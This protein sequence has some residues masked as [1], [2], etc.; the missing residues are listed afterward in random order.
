MVV[1]YSDGVVTE[2]ASQQGREVGGMSPRVAAVLA[3]S[4]WTLCVALA[5]L[6]VLLALYALPFLGGNGGGW[7]H[8]ASFGVLL[9]VSLL[10][11][12]TVGA[13]VASRRPKNPVGWLL[14]GVGLLFGTQGFAMTY[15]G[16][17]L[18]SRPGLLSGEKIALW[19]SNGWFTFPL[20][21]LAAMLIVLLFPDGR[22]PAR[23]LWALIWVAVG[24]ATLWTLWWATKVG[25][26]I[27]LLRFYSP[28]HNPFLVRGPLGE[29]VEVLGRL[30]TAVFLVSC[31]AS[32]ISV[33]VR[34]GDSRGDERQQIKWFAYAAAALLGAFFFSP[35]I[36]SAIAAMGGPWGL[37]L[38]ICIWAGLQGIPVAVGIA[39]LKYRLY[40]IDRLINRTLVYGSL[41]GFLALVYLGGVTATQAVLQALTAQEKLPQLV[42]VASTLIIAALFSPLRRFIQSFIDRRFYR[43]KY[44][45]R[46]TLEAFSTK[47]R[48]ETDL[49]A[50]NSELVGVV[51]ETVQPAHVRLWLRSPTEAGRGGESSG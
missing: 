45:A 50:L 40:D 7:S 36:A 30:G 48:D 44:D 43:K 41:T 4:M 37:G 21:V 17:A 26:P 27:W 18:S 31:V 12:P 3:W 24:G 35:A 16:Y 1:L 39:I 29:T 2:G 49:E 28:T 42:I 10:T 20:M 11:Y 46:K 23:S 15:A 47:L 19:T 13:Y 25:A 34:L 6:A 8:G 33:F 14:C 32:M 51:R 38:A 22:L 5:V 9:A